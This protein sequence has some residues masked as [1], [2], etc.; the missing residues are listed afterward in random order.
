MN[1]EK[2]LSDF[3]KLYIE[4]ELSKKDLEGRIYGHLLNNFD[5]YRFFKGNREKWDEFLSW[6]YPRISRAIDIYKDL[7]SSLDAYIGA[8]IKGASK[9]YRHREATHYLTEYVCWKARAEEMVLHEHEAKYPEKRNDISFS[10]SI[11]PRQVLFLLLKS[12]FFATDDMVE[13]VA[14]IT[15]METKEI[16]KMIEELRSKRSGQDAEI[17]ELREHLQ[18]QY[19]R[20]LAYQKRMKNAFHGTEYYEKLEGR[21]ERAWKRFY[22]MKKR[23]D[24]M[25]KGASNRMIAEV[26]GIPKGTVDSGLSSLKNY[27]HNTG[28]SE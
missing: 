22:S 5:K 13:Q 8:L 4:G 10:L 25:R 18:C 3:Y 2:P 15:N 7:G 14:G 24:G 9:E 11:K 6:L 1:C 28:V 19:Y 20:C 17:L 27:L 12:Y 26:M 16:R 21:F 23:L